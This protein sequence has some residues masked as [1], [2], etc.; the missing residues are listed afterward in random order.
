MD[1]T[2]ACLKRAGVE[3]RVQPKAFRVLLHLVKERDRLVTKE[4]LMELFWKD[5]AVTD[6]AL[7]QCIAELRRALGDNPRNPA[8][9]KTVPR[10]GY[11]FVG[12]V[13]EVRPTVA[14]VT[15]PDTTPTD[16]SPQAPSLVVE[17]A[18]E[19]PDVVRVHS[20]APRLGRL[21]IGALVLVSLA[22]AALW[23]GVALHDPPPPAAA[24]R[25]VAV[26]RFENHSGQSD[27]EWLRDGLPDMLETT[28]SRSKALDIL[29]RGQTASQRSRIEGIP[30]DA[31]IQWARAARAQVAVAGS[32]SKLGNSMRVDARVLDTETGSLLAAEDITV[33]HQDQL[34]SQIDYLAARLASRIAPQSRDQDRRVLASLMTD[35]LEAYRLYSLGLEK[36]EALQTQEAI[37]LF[38]KALSLDPE[39]AMA[40]ARIGY[41][42]AVTDA[43]IAKGRPFLESAF[44]KSAKLTEKDRRH[45]VAW[46]AIA[47]QDYRGAIRRY[48]ELIAEYPDEPEAYFRL[49]MLLRG[50]SRHEEAIDL[51]H[52]ASALDPE[53]PKIY[54]GLASVFSELGRHDEA[55][56]AVGH[57]VALAPND[58]N[59]YDSLALSYQMAGQPERALEAYRKALEL[60]PDFVIASFHRAAY[61]AHLGRVRE[62]LRECLEQAER[63]LSDVEKRRGWEQAAWVSWRR[64]EL[65]QARLYVTR[66][67]LFLLEGV[68][69]V[70]PAF[71]LLPER[72]ATT[73]GPLVGRGAQ[74]ATRVAYYYQAEQARLQGRTN[75]RLS[76]LR[77]MLRFKSF[78]GEAEI[79]EDALADAY[80][81]LGQLDEAIAEYERALRLFPGMPL[82]RFHLA[83]AYQRTGRTAAAKTQYRLFL[84]LWKH[85]DS[86]LPE[87][88]EAR[89]M[90]Q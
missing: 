69:A 18:R 43:L 54:N 1:V 62:A 9:L 72:K 40:S 22:G 63:G 23:T 41:A 45:I 12:P 90:A 56:S 48:T 21:A 66:A 11:R 29:S 10:M 65:E 34:L 86:D 8:Y 17:V 42:Y 58:P 5:T 38:Q 51:L 25:R 27:L 19:A 74:Y 33:D 81:E 80:R 70:N 61:H 89:R 36:A 28:L 75:D 24:K 47:N 44:R 32:F 7:T 2:R 31:A 37:A 57:Y 20:G 49:A 26:L 67:G 64:S 50:E 52:R 14:P 76:H 83:Q 68:Y 13:E 59:A 88:A 46:Y 16:W 30:A 15:T 60:K 71:L 79:L 6:D 3:V 78:W 77:Q 4:E 85:A 84:E 35:N 53:D 55:F 87:L 73:P 82:A 39:F